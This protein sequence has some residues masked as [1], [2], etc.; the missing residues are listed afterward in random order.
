MALATTPSD[1]SSISRTHQPTPIGLSSDL[2]AVVSGDNAGDVARLMECLLSISQASASVPS[3]AWKGTVEYVY[4][5]RPW[6]EDQELRWTARWRLSWA[7][8]TLSQK[9]IKKR[10]WGL[11]NHFLSKTQ[12]ALHRCTKG[13]LLES[14]H[15]TLVPEGSVGAFGRVFEPTE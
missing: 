7:S 15:M 9:P 10:C 2:H 4:N 12:R 3:T 8:N 13:D 6:K 5:P 11:G 1:L 14:K